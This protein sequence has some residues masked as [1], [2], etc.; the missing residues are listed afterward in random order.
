MYRTINVK[1]SFKYFSCS[2]LNSV[3]K[4]ICYGNILRFEWY[5]HMRKLA[6]SLLKK[7]NYKVRIGRN[8]HL[9]VLEIDQRGT[10]I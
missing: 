3:E 7:G 2:W 4:N 8:N 1:K 5:S 6:N 10:T 9:S